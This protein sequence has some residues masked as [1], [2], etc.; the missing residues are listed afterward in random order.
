MDGDAMPAP[1]LFTLRERLA[2]GALEA[3]ALTRACLDEIAARDGALRAFAR[4]D[5]AHALAQA[6][7]LDRR[8]R[9]GLPLGPLHGLPVAVKDVI[10]TAGMETTNGTGLDAG[11][12]PGRDAFVVAR[13]KAAGAVILGKTVTAEL[14]FRHPG[15]TRNPA[16]PGRTPGG[17]S[18]GSA[19]AVAAGMVP[20]ALGTQTAGSVLRP[21]SYCGVT[22]F[23]PSFGAIP[24]TGVLAQA[25]SLDTIGVFAR[26]TAEAALLAE[27][28]FGHDPDDPA[29]AP[30]PFP[31]LLEGALSR[32]PLAP[33][34]ACI[35]APLIAGADP[36]M[37]AAI[38]ELATALGDQAFAV[39]LPDEFAEGIVA[40]ERINLAEMAKCYH[41]YEQRGGA[42]L[43]L[44]MREALAAG[45]R[46][47][48]RDYLAALDWRQVLN[49]GLEKLFERCD[50]LLLPAA[51]GPAPEGLNHTGSAEFNALWTLCGLPAIS[52]P[53]LETAEGLPLGVQLVG[54]R[55][56][57]AR[58]LR[59]ARWLESFVLTGETE[60]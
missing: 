55:G 15:E 41:R 49:A 3:A 48:A 9:A 18:S 28:L 34:F 42:I 36:E 21:A 43:S 17:S 33:V 54:R 58:L 40:R 60:R 4:V 57:D 10:D 1:D 46:M 52:L 47:P 7:T 29:T 13:L 32:P 23:K 30:A 53:L 35:G 26:S 22:G 50:A 56:E 45:A 31:R 44:Q 38:S 16:A 5:P 27:A 24:R 51:P 37:R 19:A 2:S 14:A 59:T 12:M 25:P 11:R 8:R 39:D 6:E 20:L